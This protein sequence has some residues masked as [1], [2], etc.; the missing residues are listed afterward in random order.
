MAKRNKFLSWVMALVMVFTLLPVTAAAEELQAEAETI[1]I[2][3]ADDLI[4][5]STGDF[6]KISEAKILLVQDIDMA[7]EDAISPIGGNVPFNGTFDGRGHVI[8]NL[9]IKGVE[10][11]N[12][13]T[14]LFG[15]LGSDGKIERL[16]LE[17]VSV[18]GWVNTGA[19]AGCLVGS[20][21]E[22]YVTGMINGAR[23]TGGIA[24]MLYGGTIENCWTDADITG[25][26]FFGGLFGG[27]RHDTRYYDDYTSQP[28]VWKGFTPIPDELTGESM[29]IRNNLVMGTITGK[30][31]AGGIL[32]DM[33]NAKT[34]ALD[35]F[36]GNVAWVESVV[37][38]HAVED[39]NSRYD[40]FYGK[41][42]KG[43]AYPIINYD[44]LYWDGMSL[45]GPTSSYTPA[46]SRAHADLRIKAAKI[47]ALSAQVTYEALGWDFDYIWVWSDD[48]CHPVLKN[49]TPPESTKIETFKINSVEDFLYLCNP[50][51]FSDIANSKILLNANI[52]MAGQDAIAPIGGG[53]PFNGTFDGQGHVIKNLKI[54]G[55][56]S[57]KCTGLFGYVGRDGK[58]MRLGLPNVL[59][60]GITNTGAIAGV[61][62]G[63]VTECYVTGYIDGGRYTGGIAGMLHAGTIENC[64]VDANFITTRYG[65]GLFGGTDY[66]TQP[67]P[68]VES[69]LA[70]W[71]GP[72]TDKAMVIRNNLVL[73]TNCCNN[74]A[75]AFF[76][77]MA[78]KNQSSPLE[79]FEGNVSWMKAVSAAGN[80]YYGPIYAWWAADRADEN[81]TIK[82]NVYWDNMTL[83]GKTVSGLENSGI[84]SGY[85]A[86]GTVAFVK[87]NGMGFESRTSEELG[88]QATYEALGWD[89]E[90]IWK[91]DN[92]LK[93]P[94]LKDVANPQNPVKTIRIGTVAE[95]LAICDS[96]KFEELS[97]DIIV[98]TDDIDMVGEE[99]IA[100]IGGNFPFNGTFDGQGHAIKNLTIVGVQGSNK[101]T[102]LFGYVGAEGKITDLGLELIHVSGQANTGAIAGVLVG[103]VSECYVTG[104]INGTRYTGGI[105]GMLH[106]GTIENCWTDSEIR[107]TDKYAG[108]LFG[109]TRYETRYSD[110]K[111]EPSFW[112]PYTPLTFAVENKAMVIRNNLVLG[113][114]T[115]TSN[116]GGLLGDMANAKTTKLDIFDGN[117]V[118]AESVSDASK[119]YD[120]FYGKWVEKRQIPT[121]N[122]DNL[123]WD[124][125]TLSG[126]TESIVPSDSRSHAD[127]R[128]KAVTADA[129]GD[130]ATY[131]NLGWDFETTWGWSETLGHPVL[132]GQTVPVDPDNLK[133]YPASLVTTYVDSPKTSRAFT[134]NTINTINGTIVQAVA[135][136]AY[137]SES[138]FTGSA[139]KAATGS[140][141]ELMDRTGA[142]TGRNIHK[143][144]LTGLKPGTTYYYRVGD[145]KFWSPVYS[146][147]TEWADA[148][149]FTFFNVTDTQKFYQNYK[150]VLEHATTNY[151]HGEFILHTGDVIQN[152]LS[153]DYD[154]VYRVTANYVTDLPSMVT[155]GNHEMNKDSKETT[156]GGID[157]DPVKCLDNFNAHYQFPA[158]GPEGYGQ[159]A[160]SF[161]YGDAYFAVLNS[162]LSRYDGTFTD[163]IEWLK[164]DLEANGNDKAWQIVSIHHGPYQY[165]GNNLMNDAAASISPEDAQEL[166][167][168]MESTGID[169]LLFGHDHTY[170][171]CAPHKTGSVYYYSAGCTGEGTGSAGKPI[172]AAITVTEDRLTVA[173]YRLNEKDAFES[174]TLTKNQPSAVIETAPAEVGGLTYTGE[175]QAL[176]VP[177]AVAVGADGKPMGTVL[178]SVDGRTYSEELPVA[179]DAGTYT[180]Y[181]KAGGKDHLDT[182][183]QTLTA[184]IAPKD[185]SSAEITLGES[186]TYTGSELIQTIT[187]VK[188]DGLD[189]TYEVSGNKGTA[190]GDYTLT[191][192]GTGNF[193]GI[194]VAA[195]SITDVTG[196]NPG[197]SFNPGSD[198]VT[199]YPPVIKDTVG[200]DVTVSNRSPERGDR[201]TVT[202]KPE[203]GFDVDDV[204]ITDRSGNP[205]KVK[206]NGDGT[207]TYVQPVGRVTIEII[208]GELSPLGACLKDEICPIHPFVDA[209]ATAW[210]HD[211]VHYCLEMGLMNGKTGMIF[212]PNSNI[213]RQQIWM[214]LA[215][216]NGETPNSMA[217]ARAWAMENGVSDGTNPGNLITRQ[218]LATMLFR[219]A[220]IM[221]YDVSVGENTNILSYED[222]TM[223]SEYAVPALQWSCGAGVVG[224]YTDG[225]LR[226]QN[227]ATRAHAAAMF[228]RFCE[229][230][231]E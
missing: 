141:Y 122:Y 231:A 22:C 230:V 229:N 104:Y 140:F 55:V 190:A 187:S 199:T 48:L 28:S 162:N 17:R 152:N 50:V 124:G 34:T 57:A 43:R 91:W 183:P 88:K 86:A 128:I 4:A 173:S 189:V 211:G 159:T 221:G 100:P 103:N 225:T 105:A 73:G 44:N 47:D 200:G 56:E 157:P 214:I 146:F 149:S 54:T 186:L 195:W 167:D 182:D 172:Y 175:P 201:V 71:A 209:D 5:L 228:Q 165:G 109:G 46:E 133:K 96:A 70:D 196:S 13:C 64:L 63:S 198:S 33:A 197:S 81:P 185:I 21:T 89:F 158:N 114:V 188:V 35:A 142:T 212:E 117:V 1:E 27:T 19:F 29:V 108:G 161:T 65:G 147:T 131:K 84:M 36:E 132:G 218:Q 77:S 136:N 154:E 224:G 9:K 184:V 216:L 168:A 120:S 111:Q 80:D 3:T 72:I 178:Y 11:T 78:D 127:L 113:T 206:D 213:T 14:G 10:N 67:N 66:K 123:Y 210:Y 193:T 23:Y 20:V 51:N 42:V 45:S 18:D 53:R 68:N 118:W 207:Y 99:P 26:R 94:V 150:D 139:A 62:V 32:G 58:I 106:G 222:I 155:P 87:F 69:P 164:A 144:N 92:D 194:A 61:L 93:H 116:A 38:T 170:R 6:T 134:W 110:T 177:G 102:G 112:T 75:S 59:V 2:A 191:V 227:H 156:S 41:W 223:V 174:V 119:Y 145:G 74:Y 215:R 160:Y 179:V 8:K 82:N 169:L 204:V 30:Y 85:D 76:G 115:S 31:Y 217:E 180:V 60:D 166:A 181:Y 12:K 98:L 219:Y 203:S 97:N 52:D 143:V 7:D 220:Q 135:E 176:V 137:T 208:F 49:G 153:D 138:D 121:I 202:P 171:K 148:D 40:P 226:P 39:G 129:L 125:M 90:S 79:A 151:P 130:P 126:A 101:C 205:V 95:F 192:I 16:G 15:Y 37:T 24:G 83:T 107:G 25:T 163:Q